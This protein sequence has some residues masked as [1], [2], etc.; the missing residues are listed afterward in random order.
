VGV[1][2]CVCVCVCQRDKE[3]ERELK[4]SYISWPH[5][6]VKYATSVRGLKLLVHIYVGVG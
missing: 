1:S 6:L 5:T 4:A 2:E 3:R